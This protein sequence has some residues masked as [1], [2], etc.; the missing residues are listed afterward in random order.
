MPR[1]TAIF[2]LPL[3][4]T[5]AVA[6]C[7]SSDQLSGDQRQRLQACSEIPADSTVRV[8]TDSSAVGEL[9]V[10]IGGLESLVGHFEYP[11][12]A[13]RAGIEGVVLLEFTVSLEGRPV[14][15]VVL[16]MPHMLLAE[17][18]IKTLRA[19]RFVPAQLN[20]RCVPFRTIMPV[21]FNVD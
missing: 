16:Q 21:S 20:G 4:L 6:G 10:I 19:L 1:R 13:R 3:L 5:A 7:A 8:Y 18:A 12:A 2:T 17:A 14:D 11:D 9:P 15:I